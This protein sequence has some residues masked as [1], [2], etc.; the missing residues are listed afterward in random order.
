MKANKANKKSEIPSSTKFTAVI[1]PNPGD[2]VEVHL[3][4]QI[5]EGVL[6]ESPESEKGIILLK[7][8]SG[9]NLGLRKKDIL[10]IKVIKKVSEKEE[11]LEIK[12][13]K[14]RPN[15]AMIIT[16]GTIS[17]RLN[18]KKGGVDWLDTPESLFKFYPE[19]FEKVNVA[20]VEVPF[21]KA[22]EDMDFKDW[23]KIARIAKKLDINR[24][25][26]WRIRKELNTTNFKKKSKSKQ[27]A[28]FSTTGFEGIA[29]KLKWGIL[30]TFDF[31]GGP[32]EEDLKKG[33]EFG[34][35]VA[36]LILNS[37]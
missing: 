19:L 17:A 11:K 9:Y 16:G 5:Y 14:E 1:Q 32:S 3:T 33:E 30:A 21:M 15:I 12:R 8:D 23:Q 4:R 25:K 22:S 28:P 31:V 35:R 20:K 18:P 26:V 7:L 2:Y 27:I 13:N 24:S 37:Y 6:L 34:E 10:N 36:N 29:E